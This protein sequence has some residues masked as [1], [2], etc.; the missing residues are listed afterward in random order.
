MMGDDIPASPPPPAVA[1][2]QILESYRRTT[3]YA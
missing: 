1:V 3:L 2:A